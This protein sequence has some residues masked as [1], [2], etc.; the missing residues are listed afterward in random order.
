MALPVAQRAFESEAVQAV[1]RA[2]RARSEPG[3]WAEGHTSSNAVLDLARPAWPAV[4]ALLGATPL[5]TSAQVAVKAANPAFAAGPGSSPPPDVHIDGLHA[6]GNGVPH[7]A[8]QNFSLLLGVALTDMAAPNCGNLGVIPGS[9]TALARALSSVE[10]VQA[11]GAAAGRIGAT[12]ALSRLVDLESLA[13][14]VPL[15]VGAG[16][17]ALLH[18]QTLHFVQP[19]AIGPEPRVMVYFRVTSAKRGERG[20]SRASAMCGAGLWQEYETFVEGS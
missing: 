15:L 17:A 10:D 9:H 2:A 20:S 14:P 11:L 6:A 4:E 13:P 16:A 1:V 19:N 7:G 5:P 8:V 18:Y 3:A 12:A